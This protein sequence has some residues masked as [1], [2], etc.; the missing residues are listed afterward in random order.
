MKKLSK[1]AAIAFVLSLAFLMPVGCKT[2][3]TG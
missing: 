1:A 3:P 2:N